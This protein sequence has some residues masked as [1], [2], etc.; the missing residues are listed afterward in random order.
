MKDKNKRCLVIAEG[1][2]NYV[3]VEPRSPV[4]TNLQPQIMITNTA[5][6]NCAVNNG[7]TM[8]GPR[9]KCSIFDISGLHQRQL[10][11]L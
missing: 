8:D 7:K 11:L 10:S 9:S 4:R 1:M 5:V 2:A 6:I 3:R